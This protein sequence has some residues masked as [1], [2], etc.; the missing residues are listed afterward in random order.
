VIIGIDDI[1]QYQEIIGDSEFE[2]NEQEDG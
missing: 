1:F 2:L